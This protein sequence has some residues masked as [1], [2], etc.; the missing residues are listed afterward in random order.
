VKEVVPHP[1]ADRLTLCT[2][3]TGAEVVDVICGAPNARAGMKGV[4]APIGTTIPGTGLTLE[5]KAIRG[6]T[7]YGMLCS[8][9]EMGLSDNHDTIIELADDAPVGA[10]FAEVA[11]LDDP[12]I[13]IAVTPDRSDCLGVQGIARDLAAAG[14]GRLITPPVTP[15][16]G[17]FRSPIGV[18]LAFESETADACPFFAGRAFRGITNGASPTWLQQRL[19]G[20]GLRPISA[21][22]DITN[23][24]TLDRA[25]P[26]HVFDLDALAGGI[27]VRLS[28]SGESLAALNDRDY[29]LDDGMCVVADSEGP[30]ALGGVIGGTST[31]CTEETTALFLE[32]ALFDPKRTAAT[33]RKL[34][35]DSDARYR[36]ERGVDPAGTLP[37]LELATGLILDICGGEASEVV[38]AGTVPDQTRRIAFRPSRVHALG[39]LDVV[40]DESVAILRALGFDSRDRGAT[41]SVSVPSWRPDI[42]GEADL[43]EEVLRV[44]GFDHIPAV[45]MTRGHALA[46]PAV[47]AGQRRVRWTRRVLVSRGLDECV[48][49]SFLSETEAESFGGGAPELRLDNPISAELTDMRP[50]LLPNLLAA[51]ARNV[52][53][54]TGDLALFEV[55]PQYADDSPEGQS[56]AATGIRRGRIGA[57]HWLAPP[58]EVDAFDA[59]ADAIAVLDALAAPTAR[60][61]VTADA[62]D[63]Y[64]PGRSGVIRL[65]PKN[66]LARFGEIHPAVL[67]DMDL[68]GPVV[69]F[70]I[71]LD[72]LPKPKPKAT[73][74]RAVAKLSD[75]P[76]VERDFAFLVAGEVT[77]EKLLGAVRSL[78]GKAPHKV[79]FK[80][81]SLFD[82]YTGQGVPQGMKSMAIS[83]V[84][85]PFENTLTDADIQRISDAIIAQVA[86]S[87]GAT[88]RT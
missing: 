17:T 30:V 26:L 76:A 34:S 7:G 80:A 41:L 71:A 77:A 23:L 88:L 50:S 25:R 69:G 46:T 6:V 61:T 66:A 52:A 27:H 38:T 79:A 49:W 68:A 2:V 70:E 74:A 8:E 18:R 42:D 22:V 20:V 60:L 15:V 19:L 44:K 21:L 5:K 16:A 62:P 83:V 51:A 43:V 55:G 1:N 86:K 65:G 73:K 53:R 85:Q 14:L 63:W 40:K 4:F 45:S 11:G 78:D 59:K 54:G 9:R 3:D 47:T 56:T 84:L 37:G 10:P 81:V 64:H 82:V 24:I 39:G 57:R 58:R 12:V 31:G 75:F 32:A 28:R 72:N 36:F 35:I 67:G 87:T 33:G 29:D 48:T 13:D